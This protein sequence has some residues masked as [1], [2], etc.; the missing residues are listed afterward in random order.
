MLIVRCGPTWFFFSV[1]GCKRRYLA[2]LI[3]WITGLS[4]YGCGSSLF[5]FL[6]PASSFDVALDPQYNM[7]QVNK[8]HFIQNDFHY[9]A[10][11]F[12]NK[13]KKQVCWIGFGPSH[14]ELEDLLEVEKSDDVWST[15][16]PIAT[17][18]RCEDYVRLPFVDDLCLRCAMQ[19]FLRRKPSSKAKLTGRQMR[20]S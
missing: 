4:F 14:D 12:R 3:N 19:D 13:L 10:T 16:K 11:R 1:H 20:S 2:Y 6:R 18:G 7:T 15:K 17:N 9:F 8:I 5:F